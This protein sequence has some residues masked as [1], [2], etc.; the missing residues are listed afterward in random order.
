[1]K[2][3]TLS[4]TAERTYW[5]GRYLERAEN[6]ARLIAAQSDISLELGDDGARSWEDLLDVTGSRA[7]F[8]SLYEQAD[9]RSVLRFLC[10]DVEHPSSIVMSL[11]SARENART[12]RDIMPVV[13][14]EY[15]NELCR[16]GKTELAGKPSRA[17]LLNA[18]RN[19]RKGVE[20]LEGFLSANMLH[21][22][23]WAFL[24]LGCYLERAD[25]TTRLVEHGVV[26]VRQIDPVSQPVR[27]Q[28]TLRSLTALQNYTAVVQRPVN[29]ADALA[30]M[31][32]SKVLP[33]SLEYCLD[34]VGSS[35]R[36]LP[37]HTQPTAQLNALRRVVRKAQPVDMAGPELSAY[38]DQVQQ[39]L[40]NLHNRV[41]RTYFQNTQR[42]RR[43][44]RT[45]RAG[46]E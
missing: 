9:E 6:T 31:L 32:G 37:R 10:S 13:T 19:V 27:L 16:N 2:R 34:H 15:V 28:A 43:K 5:L 12:I 17:R 45:K 36:S 40:G 35:L 11:Q 26:G 21:D 33:R 30:F 38:V 14:F 42:V 22:A 23:P 3:N 46:T 18:L 39:G 29:R 41:F 24:R 44:A 25:M 20:Q 1:M 8:E 4:K 7:D